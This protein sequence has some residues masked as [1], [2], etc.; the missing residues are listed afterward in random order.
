M[1][2]EIYDDVYREAD[3]GKFALRK[4][5]ARLEQWVLEVERQWD[6]ALDKLRAKNHELYEV[7]GQLDEA[8]QK[9]AGLTAR[10]NKDYRNSSK[11]S[12]QSPNHETIPNGREKSGR[13]PGGQKGHAHHGRRKMEPTKTVLIPAP[14]KHED[15][16][17]FKETGRDVSKQLV[18]LHV[19][20]EVVEY[21]TPEFRNQTT[22]QR[23]HA[24]FPEGLIDDVTYDGTVKAFAYLL[25]NE[26]YVGIGKT[27]KF[28][29]EVTGGKLDLSTQ[30]H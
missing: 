23:V 15:D 6:D 16:P 24:D 29:K 21:T 7:K 12:S 20:V 10:I 27:H 30:C 13:K 26:C 8:E 28:I 9:I 17:K 11:S 19:G 18:R 25:N 2:S 22:G 14:S 3:A 5:I 1:W 4:E